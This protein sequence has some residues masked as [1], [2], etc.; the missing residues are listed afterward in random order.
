MR[1]DR[2]AASE[3]QRQ[4]LLIALVFSCFV[5]CVLR[6]ATADYNTAVHHGIGSRTSHVSGPCS[7]R[8]TLS[9]L[10]TEVGEGAF[11]SNLYL[12]DECAARC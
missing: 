9:G 8:R 3:F 1:S 12:V 7:G 5:F 2:G 4:R 6:T 11:R 10:L